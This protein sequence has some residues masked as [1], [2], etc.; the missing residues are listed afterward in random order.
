LTGKTNAELKHKGEK[1]TDSK[2]VKEKTNANNKKVYQDDILYP[3]NNS[4]YM[5][6]VLECQLDPL[7]TDSLLSLSKPVEVIFR[8][9]SSP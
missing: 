9:F 6:F 5:P 4:S 3:E 1:R 8:F 2:E 7:G